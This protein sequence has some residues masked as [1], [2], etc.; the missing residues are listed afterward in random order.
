MAVTF[1]IR[2]ILNSIVDQYARKHKASSSQIGLFDDPSEKQR[3]LFSKRP[4][5]EDGRW[6]TMRGARVYISND[7]GRILKGPKHFTGKTVEQ[8]EQQGGRDSEEK[9]PNPKPLA[10]LGRI[11]GGRAESRQLGLFETLNP[12]LFKDEFEK[13]FREK[14][15][16]GIDVAEPESEPSPSPAEK[17]SPEEK[18]SLID[19]L[20]G[21]MNDRG[22]LVDKDG[23]ERGGDWFRAELKKRN[24]SIPEQ[25]EAIRWL[26]K[27]GTPAQQRWQLGEFSHDL[28][29]NTRDEESSEDSPEEPFTLQQ[30]K[31]E[32]KQTDFGSS[33]ATKQGALFD[34][35][36]KGELKG[37]ELL[38]NS[39][40]GDV[41]N[42][43]TMENRVQGDEESESSIPKNGSRFFHDGQ[44]YEV[45]KTRHGVTEAHPVENGKPVVN[46]QTTKRFSSDEMSAQRNPE[47]PKL[48][49]EKEGPQDGD[50][51]EKGLVFRNGRW[52]RD[53]E[54]VNPSEIAQR[55]RDNN[56]NIWS[57]AK[58]DLG[59]NSMAEIP[60]ELRKELADAMAA[61]NQ[62]KAPEVK[63]P[64]PGRQRA[65]EKQME[66]RKQEEKETK[67]EPITA[68]ESI[69][70][71]VSKSVSKRMED[72]GEYIP[73]ARK[74]GAKKLGPRAKKEET[75]ET[76]KPT[77]MK[78]FEVSRIMKSSDK[79]EEGK[80]S[81]TSQKQKDWMGQAKQLGV[82]D[83]EAEAEKAIP[84]LAV[85]Q[86]HRTKK[87]PDGTYAIIRDL[88]KGKYPVVKGGFETDDAAMKY[89]A[90]HPIEII[91]HKFPRYESLQYLERV[92]RDGKDHRKGKDIKPDD[93]KKDFNL[94]GGQFG[95]WQSG[96]DG[97]IS[98]N[99][100]F[101]SFHDLADILELDKGAITL[102]GKLAM[103]FGARGTGGENAARA[104]YE[105]G[106]RIINL[107]KMAGAGTLAHEWAHALDHMIAGLTQEKN[108]SSAVAMQSYS[109]KKHARPE[110]A[111]S[112]SNLY[113]TMM[114]HTEEE[115][116]QAPKTKFSEKMEAQDKE[117]REQ[118]RKNNMEMA[119][120]RTLDDHMWNVKKNLERMARYKK[121][122]LKPEQVKEFDELAAKIAGGDAGK[123]ML[124]EGKG[125]G[126]GRMTFENLE[127]LNELHKKMVGRGFH[128]NDDHSLGTKIY[129]KISSERHIAERVKQAEAGQ[130]EKRKK[131]TSFL[132]EAVELDQHRVGTYYTQPEEMMARAFEA[133]ISDKLEASGQRSD[134]LIGKGKTNNDRYRAAGI[135]APFPEGEERVRINAAFDRLFDTLRGNELKAAEK[136]ESSGKEQYS[137]TSYSNL[138]G[139]VLE[140]IDRYCHSEFENSVEVDHYAHPLIH[141]AVGGLAHMAVN[142]TMKGTMRTIAHAAV[143]AAMTAWLSSAMAA[144]NQ[145][146]N[147]NQNQPSISSPATP[148]QKQQAGNAAVNQIVANA[149]SQ[150]AQQSA[151]AA[152]APPSPAVQAARSISISAGA[153][154]GVRP[155]A[156]TVAAGTPQ[157][158]G[159]N[160]AGN[161]STPQVS[162]Q[163]KSTTGTGGSRPLK[164]L[165]TGSSSGNFNA[166]HPR[167]PAGSP[168]SKGGEFAPKGGQESGGQA[169]PESPSS[170]AE[171]KFQE[172][173]VWHSPKTSS[174]QGYSGAA[175][176]GLGDAFATNNHD[177]AA[178]YG[179]PEK[180]T[181][182]MK[183][184]YQ[185]D[186][187]EFRSFDRG[188]DA[189]FEKSKEKRN[190][191]QG[192][193][194]DGII[195]THAD[196]TKEHILFDKNNLKKKAKSP[197]EQF[198]ESAGPLTWKSPPSP[199]P[200]KAMKEFRENQPHGGYQ[201]GSVPSPQIFQP[202]PPGPSAEELKAQKKLEK[203]QEKERQKQQKELEKATS[204]DPDELD[205]SESMADDKEFNIPKP[206]EEDFQT[207]RHL[208]KVRRWRSQRPMSNGP[209]DE[210]AIAKWKLQEPQSFES[211]M[212]EW[213][214][215]KGAHQAAITKKIAKNVVP[216]V[217]TENELD[218]AELQAAVDDEIAAL[219]PQHKRQE[220][221][222][223][224]VS[225]MGFHAGRLNRM[226]DSGRD[227]SSTNMDEQASEWAGLFPEIAGTDEGKWVE[228]M[229][230]LSKQGVQD[231]P[232]AGDE[233]L[234]RRV[235][236]RIME[237]NQLAASSFPAEEGESDGD[238]QP[239]H[240][241]PGDVDYTPFSRSNVGILVDR[242]MRQIGLS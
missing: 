33:D 53:G 212:K 240:G 162:G 216:E 169:V 77:W 79:S 14:L 228:K 22:L 101:D 111:E 229:W 189:S 4:E 24:D 52:H 201:N 97:Q 25:Q 177:Y 104:H 109:L 214:R 167:H 141:A 155:L 115:V 119:F 92:Q 183:N 192:K 199:N 148:Y 138:K 67:Q 195:V 89:I 220:E 145:G 221:A 13:A 217:A 178:Q 198:M 69:K 139:S 50:I 76:K 57:A 163:Q 125:F 21:S 234:V 61:T 146:Q 122:E 105:P 171:G 31:P 8:I 233:D 135:G 231:P 39:D 186:A 140:I 172:F 41:G 224:Y 200:R 117:N 112:V 153:A 227:H 230:D 175:S 84:L 6:I 26:R 5:D 71:A 9:K 38:F 152:A 235:A 96:K 142:K 196:G 129:H 241:S 205:D 232:S 215:R 46:S 60:P 173:D 18:E 29:M 16:V 66:Q 130:T 188:P 144:N 23:N 143:A 120:P 40:A 164:D 149:I 32:R 118:S 37:Q 47:L 107:T 59:V 100:A 19:F 54:E 134:Y 103:A 63:P 102:D 180:H 161:G 181:A 55:A 73:G 154:A 62:G 158:S 51:N 191:L 237:Q 108:G 147:Q 203:Q 45:W 182:T 27:H 185:M 114:A 156:G 3:P 131:R 64:S 236:Q 113:N 166:D 35:G 225:E 238:F 78:P 34:T 218:P 168:E 219:L 160:S 56:E 190:E 204:F 207:P 137:R 184:P 128:T 121:K 17:E 36:K 151:A 209:G 43:K 99:H 58:R 44:E 223:K 1:E 42:P 30:P 124:T 65:M 193:G 93:F 174:D 150:H 197:Y 157:V 86:N 98:L 7:D 242:Y 81:I 170:S 20:K 75:S 176:A 165:E 211:A 222:R 11:S 68:S 132:N 2:D 82:F 123:G 91:E 202:D 179:T 12:G 94:R 70:E 239:V 133:Y 87:M 10:E 116:I 49:A 48:T 213:N 226:E 88:A 136:K 72:F 74:E 127:K 83:T 90:D 159:G 194:H 126:G 106:E 110:V 95:N 15:G 28:R 206:K 210:A 208:A 187:A 80:W 85:A